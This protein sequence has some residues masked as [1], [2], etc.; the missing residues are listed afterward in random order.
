MNNQSA[1]YPREIVYSQSSVDDQIYVGDDEAGA[2]VEAWK[3]AE[4]YTIPIDVVETENR[5]L[6]TLKNRRLYAA[7]NSSPSGYRMVVKR[8][9]F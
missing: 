4:P 5:E 7:R 2:P 6:R 9:G 8:H 3:D 1:A